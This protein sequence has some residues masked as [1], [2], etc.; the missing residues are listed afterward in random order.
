MTQV[1]RLRPGPGPVLG[2]LLLPRL[3][4]PLL[5]GRLRPLFCL[6]LAEQLALE[7]PQAEGSQVGVE[8]SETTI[9]KNESLWSPSMT[10]FLIIG[11]AKDGE[12]GV[13]VTL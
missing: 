2:E 1:V 12:A 8:D 7:R 6:D 5:L 11:G 4:L 3:L 13:N 9:N 10:L